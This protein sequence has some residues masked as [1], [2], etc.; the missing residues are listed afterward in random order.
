M[1]IRKKQAVARMRK[2]FDIKIIN[3]MFDWRSKKLCHQTIGGILWILFMITPKTILSQEPVQI[4]NQLPAV[5][6]DS[7]LEAIQKAAMNND[8]IEIYLDEETS[9]DKNQKKSIFENN[10]EA[11]LQAVECKPHPRQLAWQDNEFISFIHFGV[12]TFTGRE[13]GTGFEDPAIFQ[14]EKLD[15]DQ[16]C[17]AVKAAGMKMAI[18]TAKHHDGFCL[19]QTRCTKYSVA[20]SPW[21]NGKA[22]VVK[23]LAESCRKYGLKLGIYLSPA[24]LYQIEN[25]DGLYGNGSSYSERAI[26]RHVPDRPF[27]DKRTFK[28]RVDDYNEYFM[29]QLFELLTEYGPVHEVWFDGAHP[30]RKGGQQYTYTQWYDLIRNLAPDAVI[31]GKGPD[32]RWCGNEAGRTRESEWSVIPIGKSLEEWDWPDITKD[33]LGSLGK[34]NEA[35]EQGRI[36]HW[37]PAETNTSIRDG[38][39]WR[40]EQQRVKTTEEIL[41]TWYRSVGGNSVFLLNIP[42]NRD[43]LFSERDVKVLESVGQILKST[44]ENNLAENAVATASKNRGRGFEAQNIL[45]SNPTTCWMPPDWEMNASVEI[46]LPEPRQMNRIVIQEHIEQYSQR[47][48]RFAVDARLEGTW[49]QVAE[50]TT[51]GYKRICGFSTITTDKLRIRVLKSRVC[52]TISNVE[53]YYESVRLNSPHIKR[54]R[55]GNVSITCHPA[56]GIIHYTINGDEP[57]RNAPVYQTPFALPEGG[58]VKAVTFHPDKNE[59]SATVTTNFDICPAKWKVVEVSSEQADNNEAATRAIDGDEATNWITQWRPDSPKHP[60]HIVIDLGEQLKLVGFTYTPRND[61]NHNGTIKN[62]IFSISKDGKTW[63]TVIE[64]EFDNITNNPVKQTVHFTEAFD[65]SFIKLIALSE[66]R[67]N[68]WASAAEIGVITKKK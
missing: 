59:K 52:P 56:G 14:P 57:D 16:W 64:G 21:R 10:K 27:K 43:G 20:S 6:Q 42:P 4:V 8:V 7:A 65:A 67:G 24:D 18:I 41:D 49:R 55:P 66:I 58:A 60:H 48:A 3:A 1:E 62:F 31:F 39:F 40:D 13:W 19:W 12:N 33:D 32:V 63:E 23:E 61:A 51:V 47:I 34:I 25:P 45:D 37:Y 22:D 17:E 54:D 36:L 38:W 28:Y 29:N 68:P 26:P 44:F 35:L 11:M 50:G 9:R 53:I 46:T 2:F 15:T 30:K 5:Y